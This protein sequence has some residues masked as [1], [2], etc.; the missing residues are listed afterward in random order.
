MRLKKSVVLLL[1]SV[2]SI[3]MLAA[4]SSKS[5]GNESASGSNV[6]KIATQ[7]PLSGGS[8]IIG[9][10]IRLGAQMK[11]E[12]QAEKFKE[13]GYTLQL[14]SYDD[15][16]DPKKG[17]SNANIIGADKSIYAVVGHYNSGVAIPSS[18]VYEKY[19]VA[20]VS[21]GTTAVTVTD[22]KLKTVNRI[23][24][25]DDA[26]GPAG[27]KYAIETLGAKKIFII[28]D[29]T[30]YGSGIADAF[31]AAAEEAGAE[32]VGYEGITVGEKDFNGVI[33]QVLTKKPDLIYF[34]G[35]YSEAGIIIKQARDKGIDVPIM[36]GDG[37]DASG[38]VDIAGDAVKNTYI[39]SVA[40]D[41]TAT[42]SGRKFVADYKAKFNKDAEAFSVYGYDTMGVILHAIENAINDNN[43][44]I[45]S[46]EKVAEAVRSVKEYEGALTN[47]T[48][49]EIGDNTNAKIYLYKFSEASYPGVLEGEV[50]K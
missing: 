15:Q 7:T 36:G 6:I 13:L 18:E 21:P 2:L 8:A 1:S 26:Q 24:G 43:G 37:M 34:G 12:E 4:C 14:E 28:Q 29:K 46:K 47:V 9:E 17:V 48:F 5:K 3:G 31:K 23:V 20:M 10:S 22:R 49:D 35:I 30:A 19:N 27:A 40:G 25:R 45:P 16:S 11:L 33:N 32:I 38:L 44:K 50:G 39:T 42:E 41:S